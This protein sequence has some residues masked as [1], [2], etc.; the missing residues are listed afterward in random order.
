MDKLKDE[1]KMI[2]RPNW[3]EY[4]ILLSFLIAQRSPSPKLKVG[5]IIVKNNRIISEGYN[6]FPAGKDH[7]SIHR[8]G[9]EINTFHAEINAITDCAKRGVATD[10]GTCYITHFPCLN[11]FKTLVSAGI[12]KIIY[13][14]DYNNDTIVYELAKIWGITIEQEKLIS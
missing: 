7:I 6:G 9:H 8:D 12:R 3:N 13:C 1:I 10:D 2:T 4:F 14:D 5:A 11:C